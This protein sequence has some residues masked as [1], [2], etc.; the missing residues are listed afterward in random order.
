MPFLEAADMNSELLAT[1]DYLERDRGLDREILKQVIEESLVSAARRAVGPIED[2]RVTLDS[3]TGEIRAVA[4]LTVVETVEDEETEISYDRAKTQLPDVT[5]GDQI[6]WEVTPDNFGRIAA[7]TARQGIMQ[8]LREAQKSRVKEEYTDR[9]GEVLYGAISRY[10]RGDIIVDFGQAEGV[11]RHQDRVPREDYQVGDHL[12]CV[13]V[14]INEERPGPILMVSRSSPDLVSGLFGREV[15]EIA[16]NVVEIKAVAREAGFRSKIAVFS[17][18]AKVDPVG[19]CVGVR[20]SRVKTIVRELNGEKVDIV[21]WDPEIKTYISNSMQPAELRSVNIFED[22][23]RVD[24]EVAP[25]QLSLAIGKRGQNVRLTHKLTG[26][27]IDINKAE[28]AK[29][30]AFQEKVQQ[31]VD[32]LASHL[33]VSSEVAAALVHHGF[34][35]LDGIN[36]ASEEDLASID[37]IDAEIAQQIKERAAE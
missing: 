12:C 19:A 9:M 29:E 37:G 35:T 1:L 10:E 26:W 5:I 11:L 22:E 27:Q 31:A 2:L 36:L 24:I 32:A 20:G 30:L 23:H 14:A 25:D 28:E 3:S 18:D 13:L 8:R 15:A 7:Q 17:H 21:R 34:L 6:E 4:R 33:G 16:E